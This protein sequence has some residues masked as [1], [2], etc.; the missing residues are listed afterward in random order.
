MMIARTKQWISLAL[1][2]YS[3][4]EK[5]PTSPG[6]YV[7]YSFEQEIAIWAYLCYVGS[8]QNMRVRLRQHFRVRDISM[9]DPVV[10]QLDYYWISQEK[11]ENRDDAPMGPGPCW[12][13]VKYKTFHKPG[14]WLAKEYRLIQRMRPPCNKQAVC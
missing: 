11:H 9:T 7:I 12:Y 5:V 4:L 1:N 10:G 14:E 6:V 3:D 13:A 8:S 2:K